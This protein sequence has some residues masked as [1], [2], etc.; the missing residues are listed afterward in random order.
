MPQIEINGTAPTITIMAIWDFA[1][2]GFGFSLLTF[3]W[4]QPGTLSLDA[5]VAG[6]KIK[7]TGGYKVSVQDLFFGIVDTKLKVLGGCAFTK[8]DYKLALEALVVALD[9]VKIAGLDATTLFNE[10]VNQLL[11][12]QFIPYLLNTLEPDVHQSIIDLLTPIM[13]SL[14]SVTTFSQLI[15]VFFSIRSC[16]N[17][18]SCPIYRCWFLQCVSRHHENFLWLQQ[19][20]WRHSH[21]V[22][23]IWIYG[24][25][26]T[27]SAAPSDYKYCLFCHQMPIKRYKWSAYCIKH[28]WF[29]LRCTTFS[30][31]VFGTN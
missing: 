16:C 9:N 3:S 27:A 30:F 1:S 24:T 4:R 20:C 14:P 31:T 6:I 21:P 23:F 7:S 28:I 22:K 26:T 13:N 12:V 18:G 15:L 10:L 8:V 19:R 2:L 25:I 29:L 11:A 5:S 17:Y